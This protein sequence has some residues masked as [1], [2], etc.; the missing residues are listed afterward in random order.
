MIE[1]ST[2]DSIRALTLLSHPVLSL[3]ARCVANG[4]SPGRIYVDSLQKPLVSIIWS[5]GIEGFFVAGDPQQEHA[6][7]SLEVFVEEEIVPQTKEAGFKWFE[8]S[9]C[10]PTWDDWIERTFAQRQLRKEKILIY[11]HPESQKPAPRRPPSGVLIRR[12]D[13][14]FFGSP[15]CDDL[16]HVEE[17]IEQ[18]WPDLGSFLRS[19][20]GFCAIKNSTLASVCMS[21]YAIEGTHLIDIET[22]EIYRRHGLGYQVGQ[23]FVAYC[24]ENFLNPQWGALEKNS[25]SCGLAESLG[26]ERVDNC[27]LYSFLL[28]DS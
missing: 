13:D 15:P 24:L 5:K 17:K 12:L 11:R 9:G 27:N 7:Q 8:V 19:G 22:I 6:V 23:A 1:V 2:A 18:F 20:L 16:G 3:E 25:A 21:G 10:D 26:F 28:R 4:S 14:G